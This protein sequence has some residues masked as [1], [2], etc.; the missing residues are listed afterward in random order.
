MPQL[1]HFNVLSQTVLLSCINRRIKYAVICVAACILFSVAL[2]TFTLH[3]QFPFLYIYSWYIQFSSFRLVMKIVK[4]QGK[5]TW[6]TIQIF[7]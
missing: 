2:H 3:P 4:V 7:I 5:I 6:R 1:L